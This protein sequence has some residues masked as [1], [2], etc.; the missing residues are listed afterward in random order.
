[1]K[2]WEPKPP[3]TLRPT[4]DLLRESFTLPPTFC[5]PYQSLVC[6]HT[7]YQPEHGADYPPPSGAGL[8]KGW[9]YISS[10][11]L[12]LPPHVIEMPLH[13]LIN[14]SKITDLIFIH[15]YKQFSILTHC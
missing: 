15:T 14:K 4:M 3:E 13:L 5:I 8:P 1:M 7:K 9:I 10:T 6:L 11:P 2:I 12:C